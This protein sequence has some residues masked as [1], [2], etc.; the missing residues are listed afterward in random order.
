MWLLWKSVWQFLSELYKCTTYDVVIPFLLI[1]LTEVCAYVHQNTLTRLLLAAPFITAQSWN[2]TISSNIRADEN[3]YQAQ[4]QVEL[5]Y[6]IRSWKRIYLWGEG[7]LTNKT[8]GGLPK[9][10]GWPASWVAGY[11][12][13]VTV[14][15]HW[16]VQVWRVYFSGH[17]LWK[18][19]CFFWRL[20]FRNGDGKEWGRPVVWK[21]K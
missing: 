11:L 5:I 8:Q 6:G 7:E 16:D 19:F 20:T 1:S 17:M 15:I 13:L 21:I 3:F 2:L 18:N 14:Q 10:W 12:S 4:K 9:N